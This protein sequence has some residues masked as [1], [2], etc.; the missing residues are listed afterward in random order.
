MRPSASSS[1]M[2]R[3]SLTIALCLVVSVGLFAAGTAYLISDARRLERAQVSAERAVRYR[4][5]MVPPINRVRFAVVVVTFALWSLTL[6]AHLR[7]RR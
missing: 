5:P 1:D 6:T 4:A 2:S 7:S 3:P